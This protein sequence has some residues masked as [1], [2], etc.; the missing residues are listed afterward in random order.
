[1]ETGAAEP[2]VAVVFVFA[3]V[4]TGALLEAGAL[5]V[6]GALVAAGTLEVAEE[7]E[8]AGAL[9]VLTT[10]AVVAILADEVKTTVEAVVVAFAVAIAAEY[11]EQRP[12][13]T[14]AAIPRSA[15]LQAVRR[16][17]VTAVWIA[18]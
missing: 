3:D 14:E 2:V 13:P 5:V 17:G 9:V 12:R 11:E 18:A 10:T 4:L 8:E 15:A 6:A 7:L 1:V 16:Q